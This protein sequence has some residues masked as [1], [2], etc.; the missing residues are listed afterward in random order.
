MGAMAVS[1][2][3]GDLDTAKPDRSEFH[4]ALVIAGLAFA[5]FILIAPLARRPLLRLDAF[6]P[7][8]ESALALSELVTCVLL[9]THFNRARSYA[10]LVLA[11]GYF[12]NALIILPHVLTFP[13]V[14]SATGWLGAGPQTTPWL[15]CFWHGGFAAFVMTYAL[16]RRWAPEAR[17]APGGGIIGAAL[18]ATAVLVVVLTLLATAGQSWLTPVIENGNYSMLVSKG[19]SPGIVTICGVALLLLWPK[20]REGV[21]DLWLVVVVTAWLCDVLLGAVVGSNRFDLGW[22][23]GRTFGL[24]ASVVLLILLLV[25][26]TRLDRKLEARTGQLRAS[27]AIVQNFFEHSSECFT[28]LEQGDDGQFRY[29]EINAATLSLYGKTRAQVLGRTLADVLGE[30]HAGEVDARLTTAMRSGSPQRYERLHA[31]RVVE[32]LATPLPPIDGQPPRVIVSARD[33]SERR[34]LEEQ[35]RQS[36]KMEAVGQLTGGI[37]HDFNNMLAII[38]GSLDLARRRLVS[39]S[40]DGILKWIENAS[41]GATRA[42]TLT[43]RLLS[44][45]RRQPLDPKVVDVNDL[46]AATSHLLRQTISETVQIETVAGGGLWRV[47]ADPNQIE[48]S[49]V[50]LAVN[51]RDAM[52]DGGKITIET[53]NADLDE[54][55]A[56]MH[57]EVS[58]GQYVMISLTDSGVGMPPQVIERAFE[59]FFSTKEAGKGTGLGLSQVFGF[60]KQSGGHVKIYSELGHGTTVRFYLPRHI[61]TAAQAAQR[62]PEL[63]PQAANGELILVVEDEV[64]VRRMSAQALQELGFA[65]L[66]ADNPFHALELLRDNK[67]IALLFT[68]VVMPDMTGRQLADKARA[69]RPGLKVLYTTGYTRNAIV[70][71]GVLDHGSY[72]LPKPFTIEEL[73]AKVGQ[74]LLS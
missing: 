55:Y 49:L 31:E 8:Y 63:K 26:F 7:A 30:A 54:R 58:P 22:Y 13:G 15:Y 9:L 17:F 25:E 61:E 52:P 39:G 40:S 46:V 38:T 70:H 59:P 68:D 57:A 66:T 53:R 37:A 47:F 33:I 56:R 43:S 11:C 60:A 21:L 12:F 20:I 72:L 6:T 73:A 48:N 27:Q 24:A 35:L 14:F 50:N 62:M 3:E 2:R 23:A 65:V 51:A 42:A 34:S 1:L 19:I 74:V 45:S 69:F 18:V 16:L 28:V 44:F 10:M 41:E 64:A 29:A 67:A 32:A 5:V 71:N 36:Q 4:F